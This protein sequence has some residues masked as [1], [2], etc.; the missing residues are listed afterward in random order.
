MTP[1]LGEFDNKIMFSINKMLQQPTILD[2][3]VA[4]LQEVITHDMIRRIM[5]NFAFYAVI[6]VLYLLLY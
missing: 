3:R 6:Y 2:V 5:E 1:R 4:I